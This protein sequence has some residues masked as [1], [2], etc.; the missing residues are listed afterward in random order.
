MHQTSSKCRKPMSQ[1]CQTIKWKYQKFRWCIRECAVCNI[2]TTHIPAHIWAF[3][4][5]RPR[6]SQ[7]C[8]CPANSPESVNSGYSRRTRRWI[9]HRDE[10]GFLWFGHPTRVEGIVSKSKKIIAYSCSCDV[11]IPSGYVCCT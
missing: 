7:V 10:L 2:A 9:F 11:R 6:A 5:P 3:S 1:S 4:E 8:G